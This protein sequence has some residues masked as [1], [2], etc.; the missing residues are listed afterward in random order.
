MTTAERWL[1]RLPLD[2]RTQRA[3]EETVIDGRT[4]F[5]AATSM[6]DR[7]LVF[8]RN[9]LA[10]ARTLSFASLREIAWS[11]RLIGVLRM[12]GF[13]LA[14][15][16]AIRAY[17]AWLYPYQRH[18]QALF[19][20]E[21]SSLMVPVGAYL[22]AIADT[23]R[24]PPILALLVVAGSL[25]AAGLPA[26]NGTV[27]ATALL[28]LWGVLMAIT[29]TLLLVADRVTR[30]RHRW[31][32]ASVALFV[33]ALTAAALMNAHLRFEV[34]MHGHGQTVNDGWIVFVAYLIMWAALVRRQER[35]V[36]ELNLTP[37]TN[38]T[39]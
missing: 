39:S 27:P 22:T 19:I 17:S 3:I 26:L 25:M 16:V 30:E 37:L 12:I 35:A 33:P 9:V 4:E 31:A 6:A 28:G 32:M 38:D 13:S 29:T 1:S 18:S 11:L 10:L 7:A 5:A 23:A 24:R 20:L 21:L 8:L 2:P 36:R 34:Y 14:I 15:T